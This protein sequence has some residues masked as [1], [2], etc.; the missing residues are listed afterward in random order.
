V[1]SIQLLILQQY[2]NEPLETYNKHTFIFKMK[3]CS[4]VK[5]GDI[6]NLQ[7]HI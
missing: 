1:K 5:Y 6:V 3:Y 4:H 2:L 7:G